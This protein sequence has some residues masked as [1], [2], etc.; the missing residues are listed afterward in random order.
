M[1]KRTFLIPV[2]LLGMQSNTALGA[3]G[4]ESLSKWWK[5]RNKN[6]AFVLPYYVNSNTQHTYYIFGKEKGGMNQGTYS[7][8]GGAANLQEGHPVVTASREAFEELS[9]EYTLGF[10]QLDMQKFI[11]LPNIQKNTTQIIATTTRTHSGPHA[12]AIYLTQ[13]SEQ[14]IKKQLLPRFKGNTEIED[15]VE[16]RADRL[17]AALKGAQPNKPITVEAAVW[18]NGRSMGN[19]KITLRPIVYH[20]KP[21]ASNNFGSIGVDDRI[22]FY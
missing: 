12:L 4:P 21:F 18:K 17:I 20:L 19:Q 8:F 13:F 1:N 7:P 3:A 9:S 5:D 10:N 22:H 2:L 15:L 6:S 16:I 11:D 14:Q